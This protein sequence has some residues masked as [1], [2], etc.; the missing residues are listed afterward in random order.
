MCSNSVP[1]PLSQEEL[2]KKYDSL[3]LETQGRLDYKTEKG[4]ENI[5][6]LQGYYQ[7]FANLY[8]AIILKDAW[9]VFSSTGNDFAAD[10]L[11]SKE[12]FYAFS[13]VARYE[14]H[15][16]F[17]AEEVEIFDD[18][19]PGGA[20]RRYILNKILYI[21]DTLYIDYYRLIKEQ[22]KHPFYIPNRQELLLW[23]EPDMIWRSPEAIAVK[24]FIE[25]LKVSRWSNKKDINGERIAGKALTDFAY[26]K[27]SETANTKSSMTESGGEEHKKG[28]NVKES[29]KIIRMIERMLFFPGEYVDPSSTVVYIVEDLRSVGVNISIF[30]IR[31][32]LKIY[33]EFSNNTRTPSLRGWKPIE[34]GVQCE[35]APE[36]LILVYELARPFFNLLVKLFIGLIGIY[37]FYRKIRPSKSKSHA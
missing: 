18:E 33:L 6:L 12:D 25:T 20:D 28:Q 26:L 24:K 2:N 37:T 29:E 16:Y 23:A 7:A 22:S 11:I 30:Q 31:K 34:L 1:E 15:N 19:E 36:K 17:V 35:N 8:G 27:D 5:A 9:E 4:R 10:S 32:F 13:E 14:D 21:G 3:A